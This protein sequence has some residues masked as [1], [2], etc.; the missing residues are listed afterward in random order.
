MT[1][2]DLKIT[3]SGATLVIIAALR[4]S[5]SKGVLATVACNSKVANI[6]KL[7]QIIREGFFP[8]RCGNPFMPEVKS[9][10]K[11][12][13]TLA[14]CA[15]TPSNAPTVIN[16]IGTG[17]SVEITKD[18]TRAEKANAYGKGDKRVDLK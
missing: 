10:S 18:E 2:K 6:N 11:S 17:R 7:A 12:L 1:I 14:K 5:I 9:W 16:Q 3:E 8:S 15:A 13:S 4:P